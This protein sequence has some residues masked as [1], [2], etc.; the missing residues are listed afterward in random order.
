MKAYGPKITVKW[1]YGSTPV[2]GDINGDGVVNVTDATTL[3]NGILG[4]S[5]VDIAVGDLDSNGVINVSDV[6]TLINLILNGNS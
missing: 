1:A 2:T 3:I 4:T 6:T 5:T